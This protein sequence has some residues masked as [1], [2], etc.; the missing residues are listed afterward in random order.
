MIEEAVGAAKPVSENDPAVRALSDQAKDKSANLQTDKGI[1]SATNQIYDLLQSCDKPLDLPSDKKRAKQVIGSTIASHRNLSLADMVPVLA[2]E[3]GF[4]Q[5]KE[6]IIAKKRQ[7]Q[8]SHLKC[9]DN[10]PIVGAFQELGDLYAQ[11]GRRREASIYAKAT[12]ALSKLD[13]KVT[14]ENAMSLGSRKSKS[15]VDGIGEKTAHYIEEFCRTGKIGKLEQ[16]EADV[17]G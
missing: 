14:S 7:A 6:A 10:A 11:Q 4:Q 16:K 2:K 8:K 3:F 12:E 17:K 15:K 13:Y 9:P 1:Q 5:D